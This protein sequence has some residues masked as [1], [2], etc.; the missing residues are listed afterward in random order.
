MARKLSRLRR[1]RR[2][3]EARQ[4]VLYLVLAVGLV[5]VILIWGIPVFAKFAGLFVDTND[6]PFIESGDE[7]KPTPPILFDI[8]SATPSAKMNIE[9]VSDAG[10]EVI[11]HL[12]N[13]EE[14]KVVVDD[15]GN[16]TFRNVRLKAGK[17]LIYVTAVSTNGQESDDSRKYEI[18]V[19]SVPPDITLNEPEDGKTFRGEVERT[20][21]IAGVVG[22]DAE[23]VRVGTRVAIVSP[24]GNFSVKYRLEPGDQEIV[25]RAVDAAGNQAAVSLNLR[26]EE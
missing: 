10:L 12:N 20:V 17:N 7:Y 2:K 6:L 14:D 24:D 23:S 15:S 26:W 9:G 19:D 21:T 11:L 18:V 1:V 16:F 13:V 22:T 5:I 4:A 25:V 8:P 3:R